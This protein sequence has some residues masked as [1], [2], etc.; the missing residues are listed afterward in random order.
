MRIDGLTPR[1]F[2]HDLAAGWLANAYRGSTGDLDALTP[3]QK[4]EVK[5]QIAKLHNRL[6][7]QVDLDSTPLGD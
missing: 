7:E 4:R 6:L 5:A 1:Q 3:A 2:A